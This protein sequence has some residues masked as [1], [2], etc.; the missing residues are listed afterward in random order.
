MRGLSLLGIL[1]ANMLIFQYGI[2]GK[3]QLADLSALD[4]GAYYFTKIFIEGSFLPIFTFLFGYSMIKMAESLKRKN[5]PVKRYFARRSLLLFAFGLAHS[6]WLWEGDIL[7]FYGAIGFLLL[8]FVKRKT[9]TILIWGMTLFIL[10]NGLLLLGTVVSD[11]ETLQ[12]NSGFLASDE[13]IEKT[14][15]VYSTGTYGEIMD[16]RNNADPMEGMS[17]EMILAMLLLAPIMMSPLFLFGM[18][19]ARTNR[20]A[21]P[22]KERKGYVIGALL[23]PVGLGMK[24]SAYLMPYNVWTDTLVGIGAPLTAIGYICAFSL[25]YTLINKSFVMGMLENVGKLSLTNYIM[26]T[27]ICTTIFYGYGLGVFGQLGVFNG[28]LLGV[29]IF[30]VQSVVSHFYLTVFRHG[31]LEFIL[32]VWTYLS[33]KGRSKSKREG[34]HEETTPV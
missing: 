34:S 18:Y 21:Q 26:Q 11:P 20:F 25:L 9:K 28:I 23:L 33:W 30:I 3:D 29:G 2:W 16:H 7:L 6:I 27:V 10:T 32:R 22:M 1:L 8:F 19:A 31:P 15:E 12:A 4:Q 5:L 13:Y 24:G 17:E 14:Q